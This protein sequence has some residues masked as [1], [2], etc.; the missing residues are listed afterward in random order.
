M[1]DGLI[2]EGDLSDILLPTFLMSLYK[3]RETGILTIDGLGYPKSMY[4]KE[5]NVVFASS[6]CPDDRLGESLLR[7][8]KITVKEYLIT[9]KRITKGKRLGE[10]LIDMG[11]LTPEEM[12]LGVKNQL[13]EIINSLLPLTKGH[14][15][16]ELTEFSTENL[17]T[18]TLE[19]PQ[20]LYLGLKQAKSWKTMYSTVGPLETKLKISE[21]LPHF[22]SYLELT[23]DEEHLLS[24]LKKPM[25][26]D[27][28]LET[29]YLSQ[30]ETYNALWIFIT[31]GIVQ[32][33]SIHSKEFRKVVDLES[34]ID[35]F[36]DVFSIYFQK[37]G[38]KGES[39]FKE[40][41]DLLNKQFKE[42]LEGQEG[43]YK[44]GRLDPDTILIKLR[45]FGEKEKILTSFLTEVYYSISFFAYN[46]L[47][48]NVILEIE[49]C[50]KRS[51]SL[52][53]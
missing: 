32:K 46:H 41:F 40:S 11:I 4:I 16:L 51:T 24:L 19:M 35:E 18:L 8:G 3:N 1:T 49:D 12:V 2:L 47:D 36:N 14:Y 30:F 10:I 52:M 39:V 5:G 15:L 26:V 34:L 50:I 44:Y 20:L 29:S 48:R 45:N 28:L 53:I 9:S 43:F 7:R 17:I 42:F 38:A 25:S 37:L 23:S 13:T 21:E 22:Y 33:E 27:S 31:L 6:K